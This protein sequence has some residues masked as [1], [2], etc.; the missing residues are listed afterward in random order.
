MHAQSTIGDKDM[1]FLGIECAW[2]DQARLGTSRLR[3]PAARRRWRNLLLIIALSLATT[4]VWQLGQA[5]YIQA[6]A[7]L[8][9]SLIRDAWSRTLAGEEQVRPWAWADTWPVARLLAPAHDIELHVLAGAN[10][11]TIAFGPGHVFGTAA[12]GEAGNSVIGAHRDTHFAFLQR[13]ADGDALEVQTP[14]GRL[15]R[16]RVVERSVVDRRETR[17][18]ARHDAEAELTLVTCYP[19]DALRAGGPLRYVVRARAQVD[20]PASAGM[21]QATPAGHQL[22]AL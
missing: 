8:A 6:K 3:P 19:F 10:G 12:P 14:G 4:G 20:G 7:W 22:L 5:G 2:P 15:V 1:D 21:V 13:L 18:M 17:V 16:Y 11:R 9:Q